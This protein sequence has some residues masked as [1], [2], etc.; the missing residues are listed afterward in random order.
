MKNKI[1][2]I[3]FLF[4]FYFLL[5]ESCYKDKFEELNPG[6]YNRDCDTIT[7]ITYNTHILLV[8]NSYCISCHSG[9]TPSG[10]INLDNYT[11][12]KNIALSGKLYSSVSW[13]GNSLE[14]PKNS[15]SKIPYCSILQIK[16]WGENNFAE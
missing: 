9:S 3:S 7:P 13:D 11:D 14:M 8:M 10:N 16:K 5:L 2:Y 6:Y 1:T 4:L 12:V 15:S